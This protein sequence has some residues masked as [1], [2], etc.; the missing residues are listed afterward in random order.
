MR[1][2]QIYIQFS[3][4]FA[5]LLSSC[6]SIKYLEK[7]K[8]IKANEYLLY[9]QNTRG[10]KEES[11]EKFTT[12]YQQKPNRKLPIIGSRPYFYFYVIGKSLNYTKKTSA[13]IDSVTKKYDRKILADSA[14][15]KKVKKL[16]LKK[17]KKLEKL[18]VKLKEGNGFMRTFG[19]APAIANKEYFEKTAQMMSQMLKTKGYY[20]NSIQINYDTNGKKLKV[21]YQVKEGEPHRISSIKYIVLDSEIQKLI[22]QNKAES[23]LKQNE[24][25]DETDLVKERDRLDK[26][27]KNNGYYDFEKQFIFCK[28]D[29]N[30]GPF[31]AEVE[32]IL[33]TASGRNLYKKYYLDRINCLIEHTKFG[34]L[35]R[36]TITYDRVNFIQVNN[37]YG[38]KVLAG[39][40]KFRPGDVFSMDKTIS[41]QLNLT[42]LDNFKFIDIRYS[43]RSDKDSILDVQIIL[44]SHKKFQITDEWGLNVTQGLPGPQASVS[45]LDRNVLRGC[46][47]FD[48]SVRFGI[49]GV[50]SA[51]NPNAVYRSVEGAADVGITFPQFYF[52]TKIRLKF[53]NY[54]PRTRLSFSFNNIIRPDYLRRNYKLA[55]NYTF[56]RNTYSRFILSFADLNVVQSTI[57]TKTFSDYLDTLTNR[58]NTL[59]TSFRPSFVSS[60]HLTY[61]YNNNDFTKFV[62][63]RFLRIFAETGGNIVNLLE[64]PLENQGIIRDDKLFGELSYFRFVKCNVD[65]RLYRAVLPKSQIAMRINTGVAYPLHNQSLPYEKYFFAGGSNSLRAW[66]PR[67]LGPGSKEP[68]IPNADGV[69]DYRFEQ[70]AEIILELSIES[71][72]KVIKFIEG[73]VFVDAGNVWRVGESIESTRPSDFNKDRFFKEIAIGSGLGIRFNFGFIIVRFDLGL[74]VYDPARKESERFVVKNWTLRNVLGK[75]EYGLINLG[76]GY[77]F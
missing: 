57:Y 67:R 29:T 40:I 6:S 73:A 55:L 65:Y 50:A 8:A 42:N 15:P 12:L 74:K 19:E 54:F 23:A 25:L 63:G 33:D 53:N 66:R 11:G 13:R 3:I 51:T 24:K 5:I 35:D 43:K 28:I 71:R 21:V 9:K 26:I 20:H 18:R 41:T 70:P 60:I 75:N 76:I 38:K 31:K 32:I 49:E 47:N 37:R 45:F 58:G 68:S 34:K 2:H 46:E 14:N 17:E 61:I 52:P 7:E 69:Y 1:K 77:P 36:D 72:F 10:N 56:T 30:V 16:V 27:L 4:A 39:K 48:A 22:E 64:K 62:N 44:N 59:I